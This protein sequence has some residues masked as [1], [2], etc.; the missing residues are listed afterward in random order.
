VNWKEI[1]D[2]VPL[3]YKLMWAKTRSRN[4]EIALCVIGY[5]LF[6]ALH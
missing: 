5:L 4:G 1:G 6:G 3:R 2:L